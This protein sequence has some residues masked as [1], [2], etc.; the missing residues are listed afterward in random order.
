MALT[1]ASKGDTI[2]QLLSKAPLILSVS[3][4]LRPVVSPY[5]SFVLLRKR[6]PDHIPVMNIAGASAIS[7]AHLPLTG[8]LQ[9]SIKTSVYQRQCRYTIL[10]VC[11]KVPLEKLVRFPFPF[12]GGTRREKNRSECRENG[13]C[14]HPRQVQ[15]GWGKGWV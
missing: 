4:S 9:R 5:S 2:L 6:L 7:P 12:L 13:T 8:V 11:F 1:C 15:R 14:I 10:F 3:I